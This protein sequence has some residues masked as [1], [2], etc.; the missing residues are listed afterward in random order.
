MALQ[1]I[2]SQGP[3]VAT[4]QEIRAELVALATAER[5]GLTT[6]LPGTLIE[7]IVSTD[8]AAIL[9]AEQAKL[10]VI[11]SISPAAANLYLLYL[12]GQ[13][14]GVQQG[15]GSNTAVYVVFEGTPGYTVPK[16]LI[17][18]DGTYSYVTQSSTI[19]TDAGTSGQVYAVATVSG[20]WAIPA[21]TVTTII[22]SVPSSI[23]LSVDNLSPGIPAT[24]DQSAESYRKQV[25][26][27]GLVAC[28]GTI[29]A[30]KTYLKAVTGVVD[31]LISVKQVD[32]DPTL[33]LLLEVIVG[34]GDQL[35]IADAIWKS[36][37]NPGV[38]VGSV[39]SVTN[40]TNANPAV[41]TTDIL[42]L[43][44]TGD[45]VTFEG[46]TGMSGING[47]PFTVTYL[48]P[49]T[50]SINKNSTASGAYVDGGVC[51]P[52]PRN[53]TVTIYDD[54][55][56]YDVTYVIPPQQPVTIDIT[57]QTTLQTAIADAAIAQ[58]A[59]QNIIDY[60]NT[61]PPGGFIN[62]LEIQ[63]I[64]QTSIVP[65]VPLETLITVII[66]T[67]INGIPVTPPLYESVV[68]SDPEGYY[69]MQLADITF[70]RG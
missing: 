1:T 61:I 8:V 50:F 55:D 4:P 58:Y 23:I 59:A 33:P 28:T 19:I 32:T 67:T 17:V 29:T 11:S 40:I 57:W 56:Q 42:H 49:Y 21:D 46:V 30:V 3:I 20:T 68:I 45:T 15:V 26:D 36:I 35:E 38:L 43:Y 65:I 54:P 7:D 39:L 47:L 66:E 48:T 18:S 10:E 69:Y 24:A 70:T 37:G 2:T 9:L 62:Y 64:F 41:V 44:D 6:E 13:V 60:V 16:G 27:A 22:S 51:T 34:G 53:V 14:Y 31:H 5:P 12:L 25:L 52:N 63:N